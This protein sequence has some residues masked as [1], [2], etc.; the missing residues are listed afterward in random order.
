MKLNLENKK[1]FLFSSFTFQKG[2][3][4]SMSRVI[5]ET[6]RSSIVVLFFGSIAFIFAIFFH[7]KH[8]LETLY[9][10]I[11]VSPIIG[12]IVFFPLYYFISQKWNKMN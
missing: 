4:V 8:T 2:K 3:K 12:L 10:Y 7:K 1:F 11:L 6:L 9:T 5:L